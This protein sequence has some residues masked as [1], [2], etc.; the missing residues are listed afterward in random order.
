MCM[1]FVCEV[2]VDVVDVWGLFVYF[3]CELVGVLMLLI[4]GE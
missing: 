1:L 2:K 3:G 4:D